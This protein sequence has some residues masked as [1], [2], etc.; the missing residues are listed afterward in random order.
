MGTCSHVQVAPEV[1][2]IEATYHDSERMTAMQQVTVGGDGSGSPGSVV[3]IPAAA[4]AGGSVEACQ[5]PLGH[6]LNPGPHLPWPRVA[7]K[8]FSK[9]VAEQQQQEEEEERERGMAAA[10]APP[11]GAVTIVPRPAP[12]VEGIPFN[13][14]Q[15]GRGCLAAARVAPRPGLLLPPPADL[16]LPAGLVGAA[17]PQGSV[18]PMAAQEHAR[19]DV[20]RAGRPHRR[21]AQDR[22]RDPDRARA[23][24]AV[25]PTDA[26]AQAA[27]RDTGRIPQVRQHPRAA[28]HL[29]PSVGGGSARRPPAASGERRPEEG[30]PSP[31]KFSKARPTYRCSRDWPA[32]TTAPALAFARQS[33]DHCGPTSVFS[34]WPPPLPSTLK[35]PC[36]ARGLVFLF[37]IHPPS[38]E[39]T[40]SPNSP[41]P[42]LTHCPPGI[43]TPFLEIFFTVAVCLVYSHVSVEKE[44]ATVRENHA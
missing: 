37:P 11:P 35:R 18:V 32:R 43:P 22:R 19:Q 38:P 30:N 40:S 23:Q 44:R 17:L 39:C 24:V 26:A 36:A 15:G 3:V 6:P 12:E 33:A 28:Q 5:Y 14:R 31:E 29:E 41:P 34:K 13:V 27:G 9:P 16:L 42:F 7:V 8:A 25:P 21:A 10:A 4:E 20:H 2:S 1:K